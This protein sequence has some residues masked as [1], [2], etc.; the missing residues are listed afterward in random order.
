MV[1]PFVDDQEQALQAAF[2][3]EDKVYSSTAGHERVS[4]WPNAIAV[5]FIL[6]SIRSFH[7][8]S[9]VG[10][11]IHIA[12]SVTFV[13]SPNTS[14]NSALYVTTIIVNPLAT[15]ERHQLKPLVGY[16]GPKHHLLLY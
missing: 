11:Q 2:H 13:L 8:I 3:V 6:N 10:H 5:H 1:I 14:T 15:L 12:P 7:F 4:P 16:L 9:L